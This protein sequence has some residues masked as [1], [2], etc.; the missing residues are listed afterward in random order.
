MICKYSLI[1]AGTVETEYTV[2]A[3][4]PE[5]AK[6]ILKTKI[7]EHYCECCKYEIISVEVIE[8]PDELND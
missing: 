7:A 5:E 2:T 4:S 8:N 6:K 3:D 1:I